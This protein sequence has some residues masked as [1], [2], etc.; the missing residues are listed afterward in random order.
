MGKTRVTTYILTELIRRYVGPGRALS[1]PECAERTGFSE[2]CIEKWI[3]GDAEPRSYGLWCLAEV[4]G[5]QF[6]RDLMRE[7]LGLTDLDDEMTRE[8]GALLAT[9]GYRVVKA[10]AA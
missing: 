3:Y 4:L 6:K 10:R 5:E 9:A 1:V 2:S 7:W 8:I